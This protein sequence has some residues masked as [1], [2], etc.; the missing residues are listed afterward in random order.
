MVHLTIKNQWKITIGR[1]KFRNYIFLF[2]IMHSNT[3][4][5]RSYTLNKY[6]SLQSAMIDLKL[7]LLV[8]TYIS[9]CSCSKCPEKINTGNA[10]NFLWQIQNTEQFWQYRS[11]QQQKMYSLPH[12]M[13]RFNF[14]PFPRTKQKS[15]LESM[16]SKT[17][18]LKKF[19]G[20]QNLAERVF[21]IQS[22]FFSS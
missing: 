9:L 6:R 4:D 15:R 7:A 16:G 5:F 11:R 18:L 19:S 22:I 12:S 21:R 20:E 17:N 10:L 8:I 13:P 3:M 14:E 1:I 2:W